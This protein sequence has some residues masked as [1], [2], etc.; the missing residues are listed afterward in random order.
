MR[1]ETIAQF[2]NQLAARVPAPGGGAAAALHAAQAAALLAMVARYSDGPKFD[3]HRDLIRRV[4]TEADAL[5]GDA[6]T[7]AEDD[8][9]AFGAVA[10]AYKLPKDTEEDKRA[11]SA[12][13]AAALGGAAR[14]PAEVVL[15]ALRLAQLSEELLPVANRNVLTDVAAAAEAARA[16]GVTG[17]I[18]IEVNLRGI[19]DTELHNQL[20]GTAALTDEITAIAD[21]VVTAVRKE[22]AA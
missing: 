18:N 17:A 14:P 22:I 19:R 9:K 10:E 12:A 13:I 4:L 2:L 11:R 20:Q 7:L 21:R 8:T 3:S 1:D 5:V 6:L 15:A 16:A